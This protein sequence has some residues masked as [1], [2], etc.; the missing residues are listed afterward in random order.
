MAELAGVLVG[1]YF[2]LECLRSEGMA[3]TYLARPTTQGGYDVYLRLFRPRFPDP[4]GFHDHFPGE[5]RK[6]WRCQHPQIQPLTEFGAGDGLLY[7]ATRVD[8]TPTLARAFEEQGSRRLP[9]PLVAKLITQLCEGLQYAHDNGIVHGNLQPSSILLAPQNQAR[10]T[11]FGLRRAYQAGDPTAAQVEEGNAAYVAPEQVVG[12]LCP[13]SDVYALGVLL[14]RLLGGV[15]PYDAESAGEIAML[16]A[17]APIPSLRT[18]YPDIPE[19][20]DMVV[21]MALAKS[22]QARFPT[23][24]ALAAALMQALVNDSP[25]ASAPARRIA[26]NPRRTKL[27]WSRA[28][29]LLALVLILVGLSSTVYL[30][31][32]SHMSFG[33]MP[34]FPLRASGG[35]GSFSVSLPTLDPGG[36]PPP[37]AAGGIVIA[38]PVS[39][40]ARH[41]TPT[42]GKRRHPTPTPGAQNTPTPSPP[43]IAQTP[44]VFPA[45]PTVTPTPAPPQLSCVPGSLK[46]DGSFYLAPL[47]QQVGADYQTFC[48]GA[49][50]SLGDQGCQAGLQ[51][52][53]NGQIDLAASDL[54]AQ[55][56]PTLADHAL[57]ALLYAVVVS[58]DVQISGLSSSQLQAIYQGQ[59]SNWSQVGGPDEAIS[60]LLHPS[61]DP[62]NAIFQTFVL[63]GTPMQVQG[64]N[65]SPD[66]TPE[67]VA[68]RVAQTPGAI[69][70]VSLAV[71]NAV[72]VRVLALNRVQP[73]PQNVLRGSYPFWS[74]E[75]LYASATASTQ[76]QAYLQ[77]FQAPQEA[78]RLAQASAL[79]LTSLPPEVLASHV[80]GPIIAI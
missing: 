21:R 28:L 57:A 78:N 35:P 7:T 36:N 55:T 49:Q 64:S 23:P 63:A 8:G 38:Q 14:Y 50:L 71:T 56:T 3:E 43:G 6:V 2:L 9:V 75:H 77:F 11:D 41:T 24:H 70:Y 31:P 48:A 26:V 51:A 13:A 39:T 61:S 33:T 47:L 65:L 15:L 46:I 44:I 32:L 27:T 16:H 12:M 18:L 69:T 59:V 4:L 54:S 74:V 45:T 40:P 72:N 76:A 5:V 52:L 25:P 10:L 42:P 60:V 58:P 80:P 73:T 68:Q 67:Q 29:S 19:A 66:L 30:F 53:E 1:N 37:G 62:L 20:V 79:P 17:H 34:G 22:P